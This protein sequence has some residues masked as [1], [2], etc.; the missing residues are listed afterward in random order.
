MKNLLTL[1]ALA[2]V[3]SLF[4]GTPTRILAAQGYCGVSTDYIYDAAGQGTII[5][6]GS[7]HSGYPYYF[8]EDHVPVITHDND[9]SGYTYDHYTTM[10]FGPYHTDCS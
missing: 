8:L 4:V 1:L 9:V 10:P 3:T 7:Y 6:S 2:V 5:H